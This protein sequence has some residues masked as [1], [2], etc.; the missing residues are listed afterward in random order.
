MA[1]PMKVRD[2]IVEGRRVVAAG[3]MVTID[4]A[5]VIERQNRLAARLMGDPR[6]A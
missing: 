4:L 5:S 3:Q 1:G 6:G 2:L